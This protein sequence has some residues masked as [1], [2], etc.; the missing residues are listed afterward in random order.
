MFELWLAGTWA[1]G[2]CPVAW[3]CLPWRARV[4]AA[5]YKT[6]QQIDVHVH[7]IRG[8][9]VVSAWMCGLLWPFLPAAMAWYWFASRMRRRADYAIPGFAARLPDLRVTPEYGKPGI[10]AVLP[11]GRYAASEE[12]IREA[13]VRILR[14]QPY[15]DSDLA[16]RFAYARDA[17][18]TL[19]ELYYAG[20]PWTQGGHEFINDTLAY[21]EHVLDRLDAERGATRFGP[22]TARGGA[23][24][25]GDVFK[26]LNAA[27]P[28]R[29]ASFVPVHKVA[30]AF[31]CACGH[32]N[33][34]PPQF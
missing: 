2:V 24:W 15:D 29:A 14:R 19:T 10:A 7:A 34:Y 13:T 1:L 33:P 21:W 9:A 31:G 4:E 20:K 5:R 26:G 32:C 6:P 11:A 30:P 8:A 22:L 23:P 27:T 25:Q 17:I 12:H 16:A 28:S 18:A 3:L